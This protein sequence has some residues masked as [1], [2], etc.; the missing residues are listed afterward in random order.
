MSVPFFVEHVLRISCSG[1]SRDAPARDLAL[2]FRCTLKNK[3][4]LMAV[5]YGSPLTV[6]DHEPVHRKGRSTLKSGEPA[7]RCL[8]PTLL[9]S[10]PRTFFLK[11][12]HCRDVRFAHEKTRTLPS[13][14][15]SLFIS[16]LPALT[17]QEQSS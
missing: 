8:E 3:D 15:F 4:P 2:K 16:Y 12:E 13:V 10:N 5:K 14:S 9:K 7:G 17:N 1:S 6:Q 11:K